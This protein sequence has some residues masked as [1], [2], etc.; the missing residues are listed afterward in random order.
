VQH[1]G[2]DLVLRDKPISITAVERVH[3]PHELIGVV[4]DSKVVT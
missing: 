2:L 3:I 1:I 4:Q